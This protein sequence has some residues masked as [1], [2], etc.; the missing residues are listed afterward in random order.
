M[1]L[2]MRTRSASTK[3]GRTGPGSA[4]SQSTITPPPSTSTRTR[5]AVVDADGPLTSVSAP[6]SHAASVELSPPADGVTNAT[7]P[8][9]SAPATMCVTRV[10][11]QPLCRPSADAE[12]RSQPKTCGIVPQADQPTTEACSNPISP[13]IIDN[14]LPIQLLVDA[15]Q[16]KSQHSANNASRGYPSAHSNAQ[17]QQSCAADAPRNPHVTTAGFTC[18]ATSHGQP[19]KSVSPTTTA[20]HTTTTTSLN[21]TASTSPTPSTQPT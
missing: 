8:Q 10:N 4:A 21:Q 17:P 7:T 1:N 3:T 2:G 14:H 15:D 11:E 6:P 19:T 12:R 13:A 16:T 18:S 5:A 9:T 20:K